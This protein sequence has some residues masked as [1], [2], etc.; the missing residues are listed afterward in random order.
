M[1]A[2]Q[3]NISRIPWN[4]WLDPC[5]LFFLIKPSTKLLSTMLI[6]FNSFYL[7]IF[8][9]FGCS[10]MIFSKETLS[11]IIFILFF[12]VRANKSSSIDAM[13]E[14]IDSFIKGMSILQKAPL[15]PIK[16]HNNLTNISQHFL[17]V[18]NILI[19]LIFIYKLVYPHLNLFSVVHLYHF[20]THCEVSIR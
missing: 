20:F 10:K 5:F 18:L 16:F 14:G 1:I 3:C 19:Y 7:S 9:L 12:Q 11:S 17:L 8:S 13:N 15:L 4:C 6:L 2:I